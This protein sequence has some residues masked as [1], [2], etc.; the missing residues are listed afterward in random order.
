MSTDEPLPTKFELSIEQD[1]FTVTCR[2]VHY[3]DLHAGVEFV[4]LPKKLSWQ[5]R[6]AARGQSFLALRKTRE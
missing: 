6:R 4:A 3:R 1:D 2:L 5:R